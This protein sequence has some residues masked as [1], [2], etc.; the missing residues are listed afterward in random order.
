V[1]D[2]EPIGSATN[3]P[4]VIVARGDFPAG[5]LEEFIAYL[6]ANG[7]KV[8]LAHAGVGSASHLCGLMMMSALGVKV[9]EIPYKGTG[10]ALNDLMD[11]AVR[12]KLDG[13]GVSAVNVEQATPAALRGHLK[14][15]MDTLVPLLVKA[16]IKPN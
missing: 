7:L 4:M 1:D 11:P 2:F 14:Q 9:N 12:A 6:R 5:T 15:E 8:S 10:P 16:G 3:G 13:M